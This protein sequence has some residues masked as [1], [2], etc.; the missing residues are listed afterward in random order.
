MPREATRESTSLLPVLRFTLSN[1]EETTPANF[2]F[3]SGPS[4][5]TVEPISLIM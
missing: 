4:V 1:T 3:H 2:T 5:T